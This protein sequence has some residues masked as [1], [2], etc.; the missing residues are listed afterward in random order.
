MQAGITI[1][2]L[3][4]L[5]RLG[6]RLLITHLLAY[7][8]AAWPRVHPATMLSEGLRS[9]HTDFR[10]VCRAFLSSEGE[11]GSSV[12]LPCADFYWCQSEVL[13]RVG[14]ALIGLFLARHE[15]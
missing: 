6:S 4:C 14:G 12:F 10:S 11:G 13:I 15:L 2:H 9:G 1:L 3:L 5:L 8:H 7:I